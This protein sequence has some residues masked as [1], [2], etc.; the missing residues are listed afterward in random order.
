MSINYS[1]G[2]MVWPRGEAVPSDLAEETL[3]SDEIS[4]LMRS[5]RDLE[6]LQNH[7]DY[8]PNLGLEKRW[9]KRSQTNNSYFYFKKFN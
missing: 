5:K 6:A 9:V 2:T 3:S 8:L 7:I 4:N 1:Q